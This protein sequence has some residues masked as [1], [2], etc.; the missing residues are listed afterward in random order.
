MLHWQYYPVDLPLDVQALP[1]DI[2]PRRD[3]RRCHKREPGNPM[4][5]GVDLDLKRTEAVAMRD[6]SNQ[7]NEREIAW[8][9]ILPW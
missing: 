3:A 9:C 5:L 7:P 6:A 8:Q 1:V 4:I 2:W